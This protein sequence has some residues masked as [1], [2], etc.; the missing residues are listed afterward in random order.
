M[1]RIQNR[2][3]APLEIPGYPLFAPKEVR[4]VEDA[5]A[6]YLAGSANIAVLDD[7]PDAE[8]GTPKS[9][10]KRSPTA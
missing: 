7:A 8:E 1:K 5:D 3:D 10:K 4:E 6:A 9:P 2:L